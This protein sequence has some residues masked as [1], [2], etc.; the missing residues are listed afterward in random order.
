MYKSIATERT[1]Y[2]PKKYL[3]P[4]HIYPYF[5]NAKTM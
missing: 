4:L 1:Y 3:V 5:I 2:Y